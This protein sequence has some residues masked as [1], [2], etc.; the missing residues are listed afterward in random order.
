MDTLNAIIEV[1]EIAVAAFAIEE[2]LS[3]LTVRAAKRAGVAANEVRQVQDAL[4]IVFLVIALVAIT[5]VL[6]ISSFFTTL[7]FSAVAGLATT[8][9]L[10]ATLQNII[11][12]IFMIRDHTLHLGDSIEI[13][14]MRG[15]VV[16][17]GFRGTWLKDE[18]GSI[19]V[20]SNNTLMNGPFVNHTAAP[21][22]DKKIPTTPR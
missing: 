5:D 6:G 14:G 4:V 12:G 18:G 8:L 21:R 11:A 2:V 3:R 17:L 10:Q 1:A 15:T 13:G 20:V 16:K 19:I 7:T 9:A 22:L